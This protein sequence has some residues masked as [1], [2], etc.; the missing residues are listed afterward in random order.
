M[1]A[2]IQGINPFSPSLDTH[3][4]IHGAERI[5]M[6]R[7]RWLRELQLLRERPNSHSLQFLPKHA[8]ELVAT[9]LPHRLE[10]LRAEPLLAALDPHGPLIGTLLRRFLLFRLPT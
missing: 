2:P 10:T 1:C 9:A 3:N 6:M 4:C 7:H 5:Q 8:Y